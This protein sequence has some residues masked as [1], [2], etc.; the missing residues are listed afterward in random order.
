M[1]IKYSLVIISLFIVSCKDT[2]VQ[3]ETDMTS[4][5]Q[6]VFTKYNVNFD[7]FDGS[8][9]F[10][11]GSCDSI[12]CLTGYTKKSRKPKISP[13]GSSILYTYGENSLYK[14]NID[15]SNRDS[16]ESNVVNYFW[17]PDGKQIIYNDNSGIK[18]MNLKKKM[19]TIIYNDKQM[20]PFGISPD[21]E[22]ILCQKLVFIDN[23]YLYQ[24][25]LLSTSSSVIKLLDGPGAE[26]R[27]GS[28]SS[29]SKYLIYSGG[30]KDLMDNIYLYDLENNVYHQLTESNGQDLEAVYSFDDEYI[31]FVSTR[32]Q[33]ERGNYKLYIMKSDGNDQKMI[34]DKSATNLR[35]PNNL[36]YLYFLG[37]N[38]IYRIK[39]DGNDL[40]VIISENSGYISDYDM[41][42]D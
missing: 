38:G 41:F 16:L 13:N 20:I 30:N 4:V 5:L 35:C 36:E 7:V 21:G 29:D 2:I 27:F 34:Y 25:Y 26:K 17:H 11:Y 39:S 9:V 6:I 18:V 33:D 28:F 3:S 1:R 32:L 42:Y 37:L 10:V 40:M 31:Y 23:E 24:M 22:I 15:G 19:T 12:L 14:V 8:D